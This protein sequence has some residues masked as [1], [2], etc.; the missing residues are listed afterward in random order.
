MNNYS[1]TKHKTPCFLKSFLVYKFVCTG[2]NS[3]D[4][5][6]T[7]PHF[8]RRIDEH[9]KKDNKSNIYIYLHNNEKFF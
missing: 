2:C 3:C 6:E 8:K 9:V 5:G 1:S 4:V 7:C